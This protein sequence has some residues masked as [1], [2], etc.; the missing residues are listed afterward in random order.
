MLLI[1]LKSIVVSTVQL[2][3]KLVNIYFFHFIVSLKTHDL[4][5]H[6]DKQIT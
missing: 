3:I 6:R 1:L 2:H 5:Y 4:A